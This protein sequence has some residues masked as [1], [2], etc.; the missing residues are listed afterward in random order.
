MSSVASPSPPYKAK[1]P[2]GASEDED[3]NMPGQNRSVG[4]TVHLYNSTDTNNTIGGLILTNSVA[5]RNLYEMVEIIVVVTSE[6]TLR[7][8]DDRII[9]KDEVSVTG[10]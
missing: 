1:T 2:T 5:Q 4:W 9:L 7:D 6:F 10:K 8:G 3:H